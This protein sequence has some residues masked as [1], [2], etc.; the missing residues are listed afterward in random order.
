M[1]N[2]N[3]IAALVVLCLLAAVAAFVSPMSG[4]ALSYLTISLAT[5]VG[6][7]CFVTMFQLFRR[8]N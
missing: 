8:K 5:A 7:A 3:L 2:L 4:M 6:V 1:K